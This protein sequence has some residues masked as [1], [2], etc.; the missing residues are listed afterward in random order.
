MRRFSCEGC[1]GNA[2]TADGTALH[3]QGLR[4]EQS[5]RNSH[6]VPV[7]V[8]ALPQ[9]RCRA[10]LPRHPD[11]RR[12]IFGIPS[13]L[14]LHRFSAKVFL[15][16]NDFAKSK[17]TPSLAA[18][19]RPLQVSPVDPLFLLTAKLVGLGFSNSSLLAR[20]VK[21]GG[22]KATGNAEGVRALNIRGLAYFGFSQSKKQCSLFAGG[23]WWRPRCPGVPIL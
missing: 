11:H 1:R 15:V 13:L 18:L 12:R 2:Q 3:L 10:F 21:L 20:Q 4:A 14:L 9:P 19:F 22:G 8:S 6:S 7:D 5:S 23:R 16:S 17:L